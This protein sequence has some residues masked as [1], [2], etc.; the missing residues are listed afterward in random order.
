MRRSS[1]ILVK[2]VRSWLKGKQLTDVQQMPMVYI[3]TMFECG[4]V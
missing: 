1:G 4:G 2:V 3:A